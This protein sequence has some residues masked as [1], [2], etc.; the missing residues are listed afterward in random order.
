MMTVTDL[1]SAVDALQ[2]QHAAAI[3]LLREKY[4]WFPFGSHVDITDVKLEFYGQGEDGLPMFE[5][6]VGD[7][8]EED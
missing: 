2:R 6:V 1:A 8:D 3:N 5:R 4:G 7:S